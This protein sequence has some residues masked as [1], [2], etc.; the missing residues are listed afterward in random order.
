VEAA[1]GVVSVEAA[2]AVAA[3][4]VVEVVSEVDE[5]EVI[6]AG[7]AAVEVIEV[8]A[9]GVADT[10]TEIGIAT[11]SQADTV[12]VMAEA[13]AG[14]EEVMA[15][16][17]EVEA[18]GHS[19]VVGADMA[20]N[21]EVVGAINSHVA[22]KR[23]AA[24]HMDLRPGDVGDIT[25]NPN[26]EPN[27]VV[28]DINHR[29]TGQVRRQIPTAPL[30]PQP[31]IHTQLKLPQHP[32]LTEHQQPN[33]LTTKYLQYTE[34][35][36]N[37]LLPALMEQPQEPLLTGQPQEVQIKR[38]PNISNNLEHIEE[39]RFESLQGSY[40]SLS[41]VFFTLINSFNATR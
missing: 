6:A 16:N 3:T 25:L 26:M 17:L 23:R 12:G 40:F 41:C 19:K 5:A 18:M 13:E 2:A 35:L 8:D 30:R 33:R 24:D 10:E 7:E 20:L 11:I 37:K 39:K 29:P 14:T 4:G 28:T 27:R 1:E 15:T 36:H 21:Q 32:P 38:K 22:L 9:V 34:L 31:Q